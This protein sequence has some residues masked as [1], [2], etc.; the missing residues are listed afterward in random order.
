MHKNENN[1]CYPCHLLIED[2]KIKKAAPCRITVAANKQH[3]N[4]PACTNTQFSACRHTQASRKQ[5]KRKKIISGNHFCNFFPFP[6]LAAKTLLFV[7]LQFLYCVSPQDYFSLLTWICC[8]FCISEFV[9]HSFS[10]IFIFCLC[11]W[12]RGMWDLSSLT[13]DQT[14]TACIAR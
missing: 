1:F 6:S 13:R 10:F 8:D 3:R 7:V 14:C 4:C 12:P 9:F 2:R 5:A 11:F